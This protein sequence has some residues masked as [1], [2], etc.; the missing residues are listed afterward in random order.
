[1]GALVMDYLLIRLDTLTRSVLEAQAKWQTCVLPEIHSCSRAVLTICIHYSIRHLL[2]GVP[3]HVRLLISSCTVCIQCG[4]TSHH[5]HTVEGPGQQV[6][7]APP[8]GPGS[9]SQSGLIDPCNLFCKVSNPTLLDRPCTYV[10]L[11]PPEP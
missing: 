9:A 10:S 8:M 7:Y 3:L 5:A 4:A 6:Q 11:I 2:N 1:M